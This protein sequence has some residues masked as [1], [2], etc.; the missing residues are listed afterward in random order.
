VKEIRTRLAELAGAFRVARAKQAQR[1]PFYEAYAHTSD[2]TVAI[3]FRKVGGHDPNPVCSCALAERRRIVE[4]EA[5][6]LAV[7]KDDACYCSEFK[8]SGLPCPPGKCPNNP[9]NQPEEKTK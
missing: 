3:N 6:L 1:E 8:S 7:T 5:Q 9:N 4:L 2:C